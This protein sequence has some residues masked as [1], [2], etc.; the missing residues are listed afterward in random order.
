MSREQQENVAWYRSLPRMHISEQKMRS[1]PEY[2]ATNPTG[3]T[4]GKTWRRHN[5]LFDSRFRAN[6]GIPFWVIVR[7]EED[8][9]DP[10]MALIVTYRPVIRVRA[11]SYFITLGSWRRNYADD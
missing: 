6:G 9:D 1:L 8:P 10:K 11:E 4:I 2:S 7:Y 3:V 5:G